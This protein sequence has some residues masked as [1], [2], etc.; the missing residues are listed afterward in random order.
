MCFGVRVADF[1]RVGVRVADF[2]V[3]LQVWH[4]A[5]CWAAGHTLIVSLLTEAT[6]SLRHQSKVTGAASR[7]EQQGHIPS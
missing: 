3:F 5:G 6:C 7:C 1:A 2:L 4:R